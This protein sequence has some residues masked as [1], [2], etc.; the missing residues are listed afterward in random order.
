MHHWVGMDFC[1]AV[2]K[3]VYSIVAS[4]VNSG[5]TIKRTAA[6]VCIFYF[7]PLACKKNLEQELCQRCHH[8]R[9]DPAHAIDTVPPIPVWLR[10]LQ[11]TLLGERGAAALK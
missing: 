6:A 4:G 5:A 1:S 3:G 8:F 10:R 7:F 9:R 11:G 2:T